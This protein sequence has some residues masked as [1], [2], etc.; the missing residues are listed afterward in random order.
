MIP[1][2]YQTLL[3]EILDEASQQPDIIGI[4]TFPLLFF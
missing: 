2:I 4:F 3:Q 1:A